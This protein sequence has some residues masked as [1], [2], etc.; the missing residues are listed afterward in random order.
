MYMRP[1]A[2]LHPITVQILITAVTSDF[3]YRTYLSP[4]IRPTV[5][6]NR[7]RVETYSKR[8]Q[9]NATCYSTSRNSSSFSQLILVLHTRAPPDYR[10]TKT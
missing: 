4:D 2:L 1:K 9:Q 3:A 6:F 10:V 7:P 5:Q 8:R